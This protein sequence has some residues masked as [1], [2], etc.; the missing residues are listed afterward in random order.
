M[1]NLSAQKIKLPKVTTGSLEV[2]SKSA[3]SVTMSKSLYDNG[4]HPYDDATNQKITTDVTLNIKNV[5]LK[6]R[7]GLEFSDVEG[8]VTASSASSSP[9]DLNLDLKGLKIQDLKLTGL[10][11]PEFE[12]KL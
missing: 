9:F 8:S 4:A 7:G 10:N 3:V 12:V 2:D 1:K 11:L 6:I 5:K